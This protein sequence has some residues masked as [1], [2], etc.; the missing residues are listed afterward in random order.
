MK[1]KN[2]LTGLAITLF[3]SMVFTSC[4]GDSST[5]LTNGI[6]DFSDLTS[7]SENETTQSFIAFGKAV[8][9]DG[10]I[11]FMEDGSY[12]QTSPLVDDILGIWEII[13]EDQLVISIDGSSG[14]S[15]STIEVLTNKKLQFFEI[16]NE[17]LSSDTYTT[18]TSWVKA[19]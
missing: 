2:I 4:T 16:F 8:M 13:G 7:T 3:I 15:T 17:A 19:E 14:T 9:V 5:K 10:T 6:W 12:V 18:T 1:I 11:E